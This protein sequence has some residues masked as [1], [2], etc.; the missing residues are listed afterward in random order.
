VGFSSCGKGEDIREISSGM[1]H[2]VLLLSQEP[3]QGDDVGLD[4]RGLRGGLLIVLY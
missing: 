1:L 3:G 2:L 4:L